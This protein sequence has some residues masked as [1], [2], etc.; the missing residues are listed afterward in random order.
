MPENTVSTILPAGVVVSARGSS[1]EFKLAQAV[2]MESASSRRSPVERASSRAHH[3]RFTLAQ[4]SAQPALLQPAPALVRL[5]SLHS[6]RRGLLHMCY[7][8]APVQ[9]GL[10]QVFDLALIPDGERRATTDTMRW[11][12]TGSMMSWAM[13]TLKNC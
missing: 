13:P 8:C 5:H 9:L 12:D 6:C 7:C 10:G 11:R 3:N 2:A 1:N 4:G